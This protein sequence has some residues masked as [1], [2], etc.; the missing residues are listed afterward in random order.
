MIDLLIGFIFGALVGGCACFLL[1]CL[2]AGASKASRMEEN[3]IYEAAEKERLR[4]GGWPLE[5]FKGKP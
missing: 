5:N 3:Q 2:L 4:R 1:A